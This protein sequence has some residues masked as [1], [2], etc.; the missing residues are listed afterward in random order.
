MD[1]I[2]NFSEKM[3]AI[4]AKLERVNDM[5]YRICD[6]HGCRNVNSGGNDRN[7]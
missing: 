5:F 4:G 7:D 3:I 2:L 1:F 6:S